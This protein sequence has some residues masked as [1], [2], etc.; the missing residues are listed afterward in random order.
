L[1][2]FA[3]ILP[4]LQSNILISFFPAPPQNSKS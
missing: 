2:M 4:V 1:L 3:T